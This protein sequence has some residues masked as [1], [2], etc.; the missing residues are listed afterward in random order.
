MWPF[1]AEWI[2]HADQGADDASSSLISTAGRLQRLPAPSVTR[3]VKASSPVPLIPIKLIKGSRGL[4][5]GAPRGGPAGRG[6]AAT[7]PGEMWVDFRAPGL[8]CRAPNALKLLPT[9]QPNIKLSVLGLLFW[10]VKPRLW[11]LDRLCGRRSRSHHSSRGRI[12][13]IYI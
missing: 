4:W 10:Q 12:K 6:G 2:P 5:W 3:S 1:D 9:P 11:S 7:P 8:F 13:N